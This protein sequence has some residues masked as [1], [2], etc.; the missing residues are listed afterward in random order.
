MDKILQQ[1][2]QEY[3]PQIGSLQELINLNQTE[4][5][6]LIAEAEEKK[7]KVRDYY[8]A[9]AQKEAAEAVIAN[10]DVSTLI[11]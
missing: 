6:T 7:K 2:E 9:L 11:K 10:S 5:N 1:I 3:A 4:L 8:T